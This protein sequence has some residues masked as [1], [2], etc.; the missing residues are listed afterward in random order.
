MNNSPPKPFTSNNTTATGKSPSAGSG[1]G[2]AGSKTFKINRFDSDSDSIQS[3][4]QLMTTIA[5]APSL[6]Q[7]DSDSDDD[8]QDTVAPLFHENGTYE[9]S[10]DVESPRTI[11]RSQRMGR[12]KA[13][14]ADQQPATESNPLD[15]STDTIKDGPAR[16]KQETTGEW[17]AT[18]TGTNSTEN[19]AA[20][21]SSP[22]SS[23][24]KSFSHR[25][26]RSCCFKFTMTIALFLAF[27]LFVG[28]AILGMELYA[29]KTGNDSFFFSFLSWIKDMF[30]GRL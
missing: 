28:I 9:D 16:G 19:T 11:T 21:L 27:V 10:S 4:L 20:V 30:H 13:I 24:H 7:N 15:N 1:R 12:S 23:I 17:D 25:H 6:L 5:N 8:E 18:T 2:I 22:S 3:M 26:R 29:M 14:G